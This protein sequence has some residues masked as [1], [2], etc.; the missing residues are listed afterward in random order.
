MTLSAFADLAE[1]IGAFGVIAGLAFVG[2]Q[3]HQNTL[4]LRRAEANTAMS[5]GSAFRQLLFHDREMADLLMRGLAGAPLDAVDELR[6]NA[7][8]SEITYMSRQVWE[9]TRHGV[10]SESDEFERGVVPQVAPL[11]TTLRGLTWW[12]RTRKIF[13]ADFVETMENLIPALKPADVTGP[14]AMAPQGAESAVA[15]PADAG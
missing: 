6:L 10:T 15:P 12:R 8:F 11:L 3:L 9:R 7:V 1:V 13:P 5:Q 4:Q 14:S 2:I